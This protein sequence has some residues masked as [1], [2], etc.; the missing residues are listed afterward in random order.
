MKQVLEVDPKVRLTP[1]AI[2][3]HPWMRLSEKQLSDIAVFS[4]YEKEKIVS[5]FEYYNQKKEGGVLE[6]PFMEQM[7]NSTQNSEI[8]NN[9][10]KSIILAPFNSTKSHI[11]DD[12]YKAPEIQELLVSQ[13]AFTYANKCREV[14]R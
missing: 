10:T 6:D 7:L 3:T 1:A 9:S 14:N 5:E 11:N 13:S 8:K 4:Q 2:L 12:F